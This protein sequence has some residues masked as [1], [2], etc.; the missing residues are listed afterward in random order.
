MELRHLRAFVTLAEEL[1]FGRAAGRLGISQPPLSQ[2]IKALET[3]LGARLLERTNRHV[4]LTDAGRLFL[5]EAHATLAQA[6]RAA[7]V[8]ARAQRGELGELRIGMFPSAPLTDAVGR[9]ILAFRRRFPE[10][11]LVLNEFES[12]QQTEAL[13]QG[14]EQIAIIRSQGEPSLPPGLVATELFREPLV[15]ALRMDHRLAAGS[16][17]LPVAALAE[18]PFVFYGG[19]MGQTLPAQVMALCRAAGFVP[20]ISQLANANATIIA[21]VAVGLG[22]AVVPEAMGRLRHEAVTCRPLDAA[23]ATT[24]VWILRRR[25]ERSP[26]VASF[27]DLARQGA[28]AA[29]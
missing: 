8:A 12:R 19:A 2:Q 4:A 20:R 21:L 10:V 27:L 7:Q 22:I 9:C 17:P 16:G 3:Q 29:P 14:R 28:A 11:Q 5:P 26:L 25:G 15:V 23:D 1:H 13:A 24:P 6:A 18:E